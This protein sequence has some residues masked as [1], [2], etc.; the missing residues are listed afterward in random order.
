MDASAHIGEARSAA[1]ARRIGANTR[2]MQARLVV[3][4]AIALAALTIV[5][6]AGAERTTTETAD[7]VG[8]GAGG[9][10]VSPGG[11]T[12]KRS[13][14]G[15]AVKVQMPTP[16]PGTYAYPPTGNAWQPVAPFPGHPE[17]YSLWVFVFNYP[18]LCST[19]CDSNDLGVDKPAKG[20]AFNAAGHPVGGPVLNLAGELSL[21]TG[22]L[23][24]TP[25]VSSKLLEPRTAE[26]HLAVAPHG[27]L[28]PDNVENQKT[29]PIGAPPY[30]WLAF[31]NPPE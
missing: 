6:A 27:A 2:P 12:L 31:F 17:V 7:V 11:A 4:V 23:Q 18:A 20:G 14:N 5:A 21:N 16:T 1:A 9:P 15:L 30:W 8:Q 19:P 26:V 28:Q 24:G 3:A 25:F 13:D 22:P 29:K 10:V